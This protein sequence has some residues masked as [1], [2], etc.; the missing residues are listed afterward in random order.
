VGEEQFYNI[1]ANQQSKQELPF[2]FFLGERERE[3]EGGVQKNY[4]QDNGKKIME[5]NIPG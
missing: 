1:T 3:R 4:Y 5:P 2:F